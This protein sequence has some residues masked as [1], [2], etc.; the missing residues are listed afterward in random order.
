MKIFV[1]I[2]VNANMK[3]ISSKAT[4]KYRIKITRLECN[5]SKG[6]HERPQGEKC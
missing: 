4:L 2:I 6:M 5:A 1:Y 3:F